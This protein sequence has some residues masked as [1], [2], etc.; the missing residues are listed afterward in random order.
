MRGR[1]GRARRG[2]A[3]TSRR[4]ERTRGWH[5][6][7]TTRGDATISWQER[8]DDRGSGPENG[9]FFKWSLNISECSN[10]LY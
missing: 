6:K 8:E 9:H 3:T 4:N 5:I 2:N 7:R 1:E 10:L